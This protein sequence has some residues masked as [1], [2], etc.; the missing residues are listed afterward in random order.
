MSSI[1][2]IK[3]TIDT[4]R[5][6]L[7]DS[8]TGRKNFTDVQDEYQS[9]RRRLIAYKPI[10]GDVPEFVQN[11]DNL[12]TLWH[13][14]T[15]ICTDYDSRRNFVQENFTDFY[16]TKLANL[17]VMSF[18]EEICNRDMTL[19]HEI[20]SGGFGVV[21]KVQHVV[22]EEARAIK[23]LDPLFADDK[24][25]LQ[26]LRRF[27]REI[28]VLNDLD[29]KHIVKVYDAGIAGKYPYYV[30][31]YIEGKNLQDTM[32]DKGKFSIPDSISIMLKILDAISYAH[33][34]DIIHRDIKPTNIIYNNGECKVLDFGASQW[35]TERLSTRMTSYAIGTQ[36][37][38][39][40]ELFQDP[41]LKNKSIDCYSLGILFHVLLTGNIPTP[42][43]V[44]YY[45]NEENI[46]QA[47]IDFII[48]A[49]SNINTRHTDATIML[50][51]LKELS[52]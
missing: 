40:P 25:E 7:I 20:G 31:E 34:K 37:Y 14:V 44:D 26:A 18:E 4:F 46:D 3:Q 33:E 21:Y 38:I 22:L 42:G 47:I 36:G 17:S 49:I 5:S 8:L 35:V 16:Q 27:A 29:N 52:I 50:S 45:L 1:V 19:E 30:M 23:K 28:K 12:Y 41:K 10:I 9:L 51:E 15:P 32:H 43:N 39:A 2:I 24:G 6:I 13:T 11:C 48:K